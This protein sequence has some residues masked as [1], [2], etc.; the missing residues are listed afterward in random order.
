MKIVFYN[1]FHNGDCFVGKGW[2]QNIIDQIPEAEFGY[3]HGNHADIIRDLPVQHLTLS[4]IP[5]MDRMARLGRGPDGTIYV[6]TWCG[7]FQ[8]E[9]FG[10]GQHSNF[11]IQHQM[12]DYYCRGLSQ[13]LALNIVQPLQVKDY[14]PDIDF[15][16]YDTGAAD[17][18]VESLTGP[19]VLIC[20]GPANSGQSAVGDLRQ[21]ID[22]LSQS[23]P[24][25]NFAITHDVGIQR[26]NVYFTGNIFKR[27]S[28]LNQIAYLSQSASLIVGKNSGPYTF[29]HFKENLTRPGTT[30][31]CLGKLLTDCLN[32]GL[33]L[34]VTMKF[35]D[36]TDTDRIQ[37]LLDRECFAIDNQSTIIHT[38]MQYLR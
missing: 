36:Q 9:L 2:V 23:Y 1:Q 7:A 4:D 5:A 28:D 21:V 14:L 38:G 34:P 27:V 16:Y 10:H 12:Y 33:A 30:F 29:C 26:H 25:L 17:Q 22:H 20:N 3:A 13:A 18:F 15:S 35:T 24:D 37:V 8:G 19:L 32:A 31:F 11:L 6:N